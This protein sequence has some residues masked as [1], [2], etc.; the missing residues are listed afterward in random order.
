MSG[1][2]PLQKAR[3]FQAGIMKPEDGMGLPASDAVDLADQVESDLSDSVEDTGT[4]EPVLPATP[5]ELDVLLE[6]V[7][8]AARL[9]AEGALE[10]V[11][12]ALQAERD[13]LV[14]LREQIESSRAMWA[15]EVRNMLGE[16]VVVGVRQVVTDS[17]DLQV[18]MLRDR[19]AEVGE[20]LIGEQNVIVR[21]RPEDEETARSLLGDR[22]GW[23]IVPDADLSGGVIAE[24]DGGKVDATLGA[25]LTGL[26][27]AVQGW[28]G[29][30]VGEE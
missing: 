18:E 20:R 16:L 2:V 13:Q 28:Q 21:V 9:D 6:E 14:R 24:T 30:G 15:E 29:E 19:F 17:A 26:T 23:Q 1:F 3:A 12:E 25:A 10:T 22:E 5:E 27:D 4:S 8:S 11:R 7:R